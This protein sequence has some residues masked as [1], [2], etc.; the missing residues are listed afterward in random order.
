MGPGEASFVSRSFRHQEAISP[1]PSTPHRALILVA[2]GRTRMDKA[3]WKGHQAHPTTA[4]T[5]TSGPHS[6]QQSGR[7]ANNNCMELLVG[8]G[9][10]WVKQHVLEPSNFYVQKMLGPRFGIK[11]KSAMALVSRMIGAGTGRYVCD[12]PWT[13]CKHP[14]VLHPDSLTWSFGRLLSSGTRG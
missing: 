13:I 8:W 6:S 1:F 10:W 7:V 11:S 4:T 2:G 14:H 5:R 9:C 3:W 12:R